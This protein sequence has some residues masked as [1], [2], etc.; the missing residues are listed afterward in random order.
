MRMTDSCQKQNARSETA[1]S[2]HSLLTYLP[3]TDPLNEDTH[4]L[5]MLRMSSHL[6]EERTGYF[7][8]YIKKVNFYFRITIPL[9]EKMHAFE[10]GPPHTCGS[11]SICPEMNQLLEQKSHWISHKAQDFPTLFKNGGNVKQ[12]G[13][14][15]TLGNEWSRSIRQTG[16]MIYRRESGAA[17]PDGPARNTATPH[18]LTTTDLQAITNTL[19]DSLKQKTLFLKVR[20]DTEWAVTHYFSISSEWTADIQRFI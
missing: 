13:Q 18:V 16:Q 5:I 12:P 2:V 15:D 7:L 20:R 9:R 14:R 8:Y 19:K 11:R 6:T 17:K 3:L 4:R 10:T 1:R